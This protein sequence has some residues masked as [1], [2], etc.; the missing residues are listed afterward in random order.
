MRAILLLIMAVALVGCGESK[1]EKA[2]KAKAAAEAAAEEAKVFDPLT[3]R[4]SP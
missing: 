1:E 2:A 4:E 3:P